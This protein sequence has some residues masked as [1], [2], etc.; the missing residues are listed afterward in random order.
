M[1]D[2]QTLLKMTVLKLREEA[3]KIEGISGVHGMNKQQLLDVLFDQFGIPRDVKARKDNT[4]LK[5]AIKGY[6]AKQP[7]ARA[8][9]DKKK[10]K[11]IQR[12]IHALKRQT[13]K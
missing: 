7:E 10:A 5:K 11:K 9:G 12:K 3:L 8:A 2:K 6:R 13:R 1:M 4:E